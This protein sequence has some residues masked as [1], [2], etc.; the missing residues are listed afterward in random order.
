MFKKSILNKRLC[1]I[2]ITL[3]LSLYSFSQTK[4]RAFV[5]TTD[6]DLDGIIDSVD[7]DDDNDGILDSDEITR[8]FLQLSSTDLG[9]SINDFNQSGTADVSDQYGYAANSGNVVVTYNHIN[10]GPGGGLYSYNGLPNPTYTITSTISTL[11]RLDHGK[12]LQAGGTDGFIVSDGS[13]YTFTTTLIAGIA[14]TSAGNTLS[15]I[16]NNTGVTNNGNN[17]YVWEQTSPYSTTNSFQVITNAIPGNNAGY[18]IFIS[19]PQDTDNDGIPD[20][21][22]LDSDND[23]CSDA[24][25]GGTTTDQTTNYQFPSNDVDGDGIPNTA[26]AYNNSGNPY[27][28]DTALVIVHLLQE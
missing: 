22:D 16:N 13:S 15:V 12:T 6:T 11:L 3:S 1:C 7:L 8:N 24:I 19:I 26:L 9:L 17:R 18:R 23:A 2:I 20:Y 14:N 10:V 25:E 28:T 21:L 5:N 4:Q 27:D